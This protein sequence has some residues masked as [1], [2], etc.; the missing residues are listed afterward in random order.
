[1]AA[2]LPC[3]VTDWDGYKD[4]VRHGEDGFRVGVPLT[5]ICLVFS[6]LSMA[7]AGRLVACQIEELAATIAYRRNVAPAVQKTDLPGARS[8]AE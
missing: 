7:E 4:T 5:L 3:V 1:M 8:A 6:Y 2:G